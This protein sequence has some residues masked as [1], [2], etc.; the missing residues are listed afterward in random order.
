MKKIIHKYTL[1]T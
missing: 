1:L